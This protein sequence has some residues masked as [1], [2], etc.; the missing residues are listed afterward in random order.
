MHKMY[1]KG[2]SAVWATVYW[3]RP[4]CGVKVIEAGGDSQKFYFSHRFNSAAAQIYQ[5][6]KLIE[7]FVWCEPGWWD[8]EKALDFHQLLIITGHAAQEKFE[9]MTKNA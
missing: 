4:A 3:N 6:N 7:K 5:A 9:A 1:V 8:T 2:K